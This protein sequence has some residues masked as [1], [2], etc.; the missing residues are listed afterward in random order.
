M[1]E[2]KQVDVAIVGGGPAGM[3]AAIAARRAGSS[4]VVID[5]YAA[6]GGQIWRRRFD[7]VGASA[8]KSLPPE[9]RAQVAEFTA[10]G[11]ELLAGR[12]VWGTPEPGVLMLTGD[13][14]SRVRARAIVLC[15]GAYDRPVAFPGWTLPG[16][17]TAGGA[18]ALAKGQGVLPGKRVL[19][20]GAGPFLLPV[21][22]QLASLGA[23]IVAVAEATRRR[24]WVGVGP[25]MA[26]HPAR[27]VDY[28]KY[29]TRVRK[30][31]WGHVIVRASGEG[32]VR[33]ATIA[34]AGPDW[35]PTGAEKTFEV[36]AVCTAY[37]FLPSVDLAR[38]LG[39]ELAG[40]AVAH[41]E[42]MQTSVKGVFVAGEA[43]GIGGADLALA[44]GELAGYTAAAHAASPGTAG[45]DGHAGP[46]A[47]A[48]GRFGA[49][50]ADGARPNGV[51]PAR[52]AVDL[53][54]L[55]ARRAKLANFAGI[56]ADLFDPRPGLRTLVDADT[57]LC[58][59]EDVTAGAVDAAVAGGATTLSALKVV[60]R[61]GQGPCQG[62]VC[63]RLVAARVPAP[64]RFSAR[65]PIRPIPLGLLMA[66]AT[67]S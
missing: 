15:T 22:A 43:T 8:P 42:D 39:C 12:S 20:A 13:G 63:E 16:V 38:A 44:E 30:I 27:L 34:E 10:S 17:M 52:P 53:A 19:L 3:A 11:A 28:A 67:D 60:T 9:A 46:L 6:P 18:Q 35:A 58:R 4:V 49:A 66:E 41:N 36:D 14:P 32:R 47:G 23:E 29:R 5:E 37:G 48:T 61:C 51:V 62:R 64:E 65:E 55:R 59:C 56:L 54:P 31:V 50:K 26:A 57:T 33:T 2:E 25:R 45:V 7:E 21:A 24:E 40:D 1:S